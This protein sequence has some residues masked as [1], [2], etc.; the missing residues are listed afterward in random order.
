MK[1]KFVIVLLVG[2]FVT[3]VVCPMPILAQN[4]LTNGDL[5]LIEPGFWM[6]V[7]EGDGGST[8]SWPW[9]GK[10]S[11]RSFEI[12]KPNASGAAVGWL[13][14]NNADLYWNNAKANQLYN[15]TFWAKTE[16]VN[17]SPANDDGKI[18]VHFEIFLAGTLLSDEFV[19]ADQTVD[20]KDWTEYTGGVAIGAEEPDSVVA[21]I[22]FGKDATGKAY[23]DNVNCGTSPDWSMGLFNGNAETPVGW[24][25]WSDG[26][27]IGFA[28]LDTANAHSGDYAALQRERDTNDDEMVF[29]STPVAVEPNEWYKISVWAKLDSVNTGAGWFGTNVTTDYDM[30]RMGINFFYHRDSI[31]RAWDLTGGDQFIY[32]DQRDSTHDWRQ[33]T[34]ISKAPEDAA[35]LSMRARFNSMTMGYAWYDDFSIE[36]LD[37]DPNLLVNGDLELIEPGFWTKVN[38]GDGGSTLSWPWMGKESERSFE[39]TKPNAS[40]AAVGW[41]SVNNAD[42]YWNNAKANQL[43]NFTFWAKTEGVNTSPANDDGKIGVHFEIFLAGT[44]LSDEFVW[45]DQ[46]VDTKDWTEYTGGVAIGAEE[47]DSVVATILF[48]KD[49]TGKAYFDNVNCGTS[50]DWSMGLFNG[51]AETPVGWM[52]WSD[53]GKIGFANLDTANAHSGDY[54][55]LQRERDTNDDEMVFYSTPVAVEPNEWYKISVWAKLDSVNTGAGWFG[56]NVTTDYDMDRMGINFFYHR[57]SIV[58][59]WDLTGGDQFIYFD[60]RDSTHD[61]RQYTIISKAPEDAAGLSMRARFN[62]MTMGYAWYDDFSIEPVEILITGVEE[63]DL[64]AQ[65]LIPAEYELRQNYPNPFN[66]TTMIEFKLPKA[67]QINLDIFNILGQRVRLLTGGFHRAGTFKLLWNAR[68]DY[69]QKVPTGIYFYRL[70]AGDYITMKKMILMK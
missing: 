23:F 26:G 22:L 47:P 14:V 39:I 70:R 41:L 64:I 32:F 30:D 52:N 55:A 46:T 40:G 6:K 9:M 15:F 20:T 37:L 13:S 49:A 31:V 67:G 19:W 38:E 29:Y 68:N 56:T 11:E 69:G 24:M 51:N 2:M 17:T 10:E 57:D 1:T 48:G 3:V 27:K 45:A 16:G 18:G 28:N 54:A 25:N 7:N 21:T 60:Q 62:S 42:L 8:L 61:W 5:E 44:L 33:Y 34:I 59:A 35:G 36:H 50:P 66:P 53:G 12:T 65:G 43:Y 63:A 58:R 4:I